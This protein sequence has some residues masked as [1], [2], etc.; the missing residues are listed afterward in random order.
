MPSERERDGDGQYLQTAESDDLDRKAVALFRQKKRYRQIAEE[1]GISVGSAHQRVRRCLD[2]A[3]LR[4]A[5]E[6]IPDM[7]DELETERAILK[8]TREEALAEL[9]HGRM[10]ANPDDPDGP[11]IEDPEYRL[12]VM[13]RLIKFADQIQKNTESLRRLRGLDQPAQ[14]QVTQ[15]V[16]YKIVGMNDE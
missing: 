6:A 16:T 13:D 12:K 8:D 5:M 9:E 10:I 11:A 14:Q 4:P 2:M 15:E 3:R 1:L 7:I